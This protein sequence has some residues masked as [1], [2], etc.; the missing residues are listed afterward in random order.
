MNLQLSDIASE[1]LSQ[2]SQQLELSPDEFASL[3]FEY[4]DIKHRGI[5]AAADKLKQSKEKTIVNKTNLDQHLQQLSPE[6]VELLL[7][8]AAQKRK[9]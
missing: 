2:L 8:K 1:K 6:Q 5:Q 3:C 7:M 9:S 4:V